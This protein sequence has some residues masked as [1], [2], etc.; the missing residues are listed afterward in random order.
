MITPPLMNVMR[1]VRRLGL[2]RAGSIATI[3]VYGTALGNDVRT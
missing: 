2:R 1:T 3:S